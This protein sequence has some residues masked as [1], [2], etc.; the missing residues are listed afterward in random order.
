MR[1]LDVQLW[2]EGGE[3]VVT[4]TVEGELKRP[5]SAVERARERATA[6]GY[7]EVALKEVSLTEPAA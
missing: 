3:D 4:Y 2:V 7:D 5:G 6:D 1:K